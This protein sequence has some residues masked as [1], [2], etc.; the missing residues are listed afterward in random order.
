MFFSSALTTFFRMGHMLDHKPSPNK[1][2]VA[3]ISSIFSN[4]SGM[5]LKINRKGKL[6][7]SQIC[8]NYTTLLN[9]QWLKEELKRKIRIYLETNK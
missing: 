5:N 1:F 9:N 3:I 8:G 4:H 7:E 2:K 6:E